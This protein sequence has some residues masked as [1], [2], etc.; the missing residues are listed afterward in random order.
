MRRWRWASR[1]LG[2]VISSALVG[3]MPAMGATLPQ[4]RVSD[5][6]RYFVTEE[7]APFLY[8]ADTAWTLLE[9]T[10]Q[11]ID[12]YLQD[13]AKK[14]FTVIQISVAGFNALTVPN[15]YGQTIFVDQNPAHPNEAYF[16]LLD[17]VVNKAESL[18]LYVAL[19]PL[20]ANNCER[21][22]HIDGFPDDPHANVL[23]RSTAFSYGKF[24]GERY[25]EKPVIWILG[26]DWFAT[27]YE[28]IWRS[29]A[30]GLEHGEDGTYHHLM[31]YHE[32]SP[33]S[34]SLWFQNDTWLSFNMM[35]TGHTVLNRNYDL[36]A[37]DWERTP[38]KPIVDGEGGYEG[39]SDAMAPATR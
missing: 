10:R 5:N 9:C 26:G 36:I 18:K 38:V 24:L 25:R 2:T 32:K 7:G 34:S 14:G 35:Q 22:G 33:H 37:A 28:D 31:T 3:G 13:R 19:V 1:L 39:I 8:L 12:T 15:A 23:N 30:D 17:Y 11:D 6:G 4:L 27:G 20:W 21:P 16:Q 29:M